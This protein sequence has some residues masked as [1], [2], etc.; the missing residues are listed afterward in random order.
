[1]G[2]GGGLLAGWS[3]SRLELLCIVQLGL[4]SMFMFTGF[5]TQGFIVESVLHSVS[6]KDPARISPYAGYYGSFSH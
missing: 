5:D 1:M 2:A 4:G 6:T 3:L